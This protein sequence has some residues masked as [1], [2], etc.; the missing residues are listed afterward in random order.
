MRNNKK[1]A[2]TVL[3]LCYASKRVTNG[4]QTVG[5]TNAPEAICLSNF[6][7]NK[8]NG[9]TNRKKKEEKSESKLDSH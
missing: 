3:M 4:G 6:F 7:K 1:I 5:R 2:C 9:H 8:A